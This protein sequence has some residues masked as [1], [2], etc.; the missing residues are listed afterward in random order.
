VVW[1]VVKDHRGFI[2]VHS[3]EG[4]GTTFFLYFPAILEEVDTRDIAVSIEDCRGRGESVLVVDDE[5]QQRE[6]ASGILTELGYKVQT[7]PSGEEALK[8]L[9]TTQVDVVVLDM[10]MDPGMDGLE[11]YRKILAHHPCQKAIIVSGFSGEGRVAQARALGAGTY[12]SKPYLM[13][14][15]GVAVR[16]ELDR[17]IGNSSL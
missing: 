5:G 8:Y 13:D 16:Q 14:R 7:L 11:T 9:S 2:D 4:R 10:I 1:G 15:L 3:R 17:D 6:L 12:V